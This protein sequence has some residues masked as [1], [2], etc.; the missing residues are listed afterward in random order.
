METTSAE[1]SSQVAFSG[2]AEASQWWLARALAALEDTR[3]MAMLWEGDVKV[4]VFYSRWRSHA[5]VQKYSIEVAR[6]HSSRLFIGG[7][8]ANA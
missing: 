5:I 3:D 4:P 8:A 6:A 2:V 1:Q 7:P